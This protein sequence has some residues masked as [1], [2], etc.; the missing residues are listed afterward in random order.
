VGSAAGAFLVEADH[1]A[2][3]I[4]E[5]GNPLAARFGVDRGSCDDLAAV[6]DDC[7]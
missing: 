7:V 1:V 4:A 5:G 6:F 2:G 3:W